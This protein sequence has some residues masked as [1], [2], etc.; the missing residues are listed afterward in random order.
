VSVFSDFSARA[1][2]AENPV[3]DT[4]VFWMQWTPWR[5]FSGRFSRRDAIATERTNAVSEA[6][7]GNQVPVAALA[8]VAHRFDFS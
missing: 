2:R 6:A 1:D 8:D 5:L 3:D 7:P 4:E